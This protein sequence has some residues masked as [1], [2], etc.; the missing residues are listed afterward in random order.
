[1]SIVILKDFTEREFASTDTRFRKWPIM[2]WIEDNCAE[3]FECAREEVALVED[4][5]SG[6]EIIHIGGIPSARLIHRG[7]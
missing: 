1:M 4:E 7:L 6:E 2:D 3:W 5:E